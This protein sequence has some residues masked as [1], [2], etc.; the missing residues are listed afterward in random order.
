METGDITIIFL[1]VNRVPQKWA[2]FHKEKL[3]EAAGNAPMITI[4]RE[5]MNWGK[6]LLQTEPHSASNIY[7]QLLRGAKAAV[8]DYIGVA[9]DDVLYP[10]E[11]F[12]FRPSLDTFAY[13]MNRFNVFTWGTPIYFWKDRM[14]NATLIAPRLLTIK[15]LKERF[16]KYPDGTPEY[17]T[18]ELGRAKVEEKLGIT[19]RKS[20]WFSTELSIVKIDHEYGIDRLATTHRKARG[21]LQCYDIPHWGKAENIIKKFK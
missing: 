2:E 21:I 17:F 15:A 7:F 11:H 14:I 18:G 12:A 8:T 10:R 4:S 6:N 3:L 19:S 20:V 5:P 1:T 9:E 16:N 13:N